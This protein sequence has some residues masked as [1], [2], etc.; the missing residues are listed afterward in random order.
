MR[1]QIGKLRAI[2]E[3]ET[4]PLV[5]RDVQ[6][7]CF[8]SVVVLSITDEDNNELA[9]ASLSLKDAD[10]IKT[11]LTEA[12][13]TCEKVKPNTRLYCQAIFYW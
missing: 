2:G 7:E 9:L 11:M 8:D 5:Y 3:I 13:E 12:I 6:I 10:K 1:K 4:P